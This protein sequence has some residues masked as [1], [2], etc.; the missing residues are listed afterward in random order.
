MLETIRE[1]LPEL[2]LGLVIFLTTL[3]QINSE[4]LKRTK[5][6]NKEREELLEKI[7]HQEK[8]ISK[9]TVLVKRQTAI[10]KEL[11]PLAAKVPIIESQMDAMKLERTQMV[12]YI[13]KLESRIK[14]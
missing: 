14:P 7:D 1:I 12:R 13:K 4:R 3:N 2:S 9:L 8:L 10:I 11:R 5:I 6:E